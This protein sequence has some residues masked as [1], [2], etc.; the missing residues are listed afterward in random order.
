MLASAIMIQF[1]PVPSP[2]KWLL[3]AFLL[4]VG[5]WLW[6]RPEAQR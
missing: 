3:P 2:V 5:I 6:C 1:S 4:C